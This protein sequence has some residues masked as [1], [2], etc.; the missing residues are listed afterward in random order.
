MS[1]SSN[2]NGALLGI[3]LVLFAACG[4][5]RVYGASISC[6]FKSSPCFLRRMRCPSECPT[7]SNSNPKSKVCH[8]NCNSPVCKPEC[9]HPKPN[10]NAPGAA[11]H[12]PRFIGGD[13]IVFYFH[14]KSN[15]HFSLVSDRNIQINGR[16][17]GLRP[18]GRTR[19]FTWIQALGLLFGS[20]Q[21]F[22][23]E[24][25][26]AASWDP[27]TDHL[28]FSYDGADL[29]I[30]EGHL[31]AWVS[32]DGSIR[33]ERSS[34]KNS[35]TVTVRSVAEISV[36]AVPVTREDDQIH[37]Y[38][39]PADDCFAHLE[40]QFRFSRLS[41][42]VDGVLGRTYRPDF[43]NPARP[44]VA[45]PVVGGEDKFRTTSLLSADCATC[46]FSTHPA[47]VGQPGSS[48]TDYSSSLLDCTSSA[49]SGN[50]IVCRR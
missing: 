12:D 15:E 8:V 7:T 21:S 30:P 44:G 47:A 32:T 13:G 46:I 40:V 6:T 45:M 10:C 9:K 25:R 41:P 11:C 39:L 4:F 42:D 20:D 27:E 50:G 16:F 31:S 43:E 48:T 3:F 5:V 34:D 17:I 18:A 26:R 36:N 22:S 29:A 37:S 28:R 35:V 1:S 14:G 38:R 33:V 19:D 23:V 24:A 49:T 2:N